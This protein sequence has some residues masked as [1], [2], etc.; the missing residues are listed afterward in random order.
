M[1]NWHA[2]ITISRYT[3]LEAMKNRFIILLMLGVLVLFGIA[4]FASMLVTIETRETATA[5]L[6]AGIRFFTIFSMGLFAISS[7]AIDFNDKLLEVVLSHAFPRAFYY[8]GKYLGFIWVS[9]LLLTAIGFLLLFYVPYYAVLIWIASLL[10]ELLIML[11]FGL[12]CLFGTCQIVSAFIILNAFYFL[13]RTIEVIQFISHSPLLETTNPLG[14]I[15]Q[16]GIEVVAFLLPNFA[17]YTKTEWLVDPASA[18]SLQLVFIFV[19]TLVYVCLISAMALFDL[20]RKE[21]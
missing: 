6:S 14:D 4:E 1:K 18:T 20:Y 16:L 19:Q 7:T 21:L 5:L 17:T 12:F 15:M 9:M 3:F 13:C 8:F 11:S 2:I 10:C